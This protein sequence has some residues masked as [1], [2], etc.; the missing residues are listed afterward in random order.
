MTI[1]A[2]QTI[3]GDATQTMADPHKQI[4]DGNILEHI[5]E[6]CKPKGRNVSGRSWKMRPQK[7]ASTLVK[8]RTNN[9]STDW[10]RKEALKRAKSEAREIQEELKQEKLKALQLKKERRLENEK[11]RAENELKVIQKSVQTLNPN[12]VG[13]TMKALSKKQLRNIK[14]TRLNTKTGVVEYVSAYAK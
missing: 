13:L 10:D 11:R 2:T 8:T 5:E 1:T 3:K 6:T 14:K 4:L 12:K 7:R 9:L